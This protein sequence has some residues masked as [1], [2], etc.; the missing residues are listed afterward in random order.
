MGL[1]TTRNGLQIRQVLYGRSNA[2]LIGNGQDF[3]LVDT[4]RRNKLERLEQKFKDYGVTPANLSALILTHGHFDRAENAAVIQENYHT[5]VVI[6]RCEAGYL[7]HGDSP[8]PR[9][10]NKVTRRLSERFVPVLQS[11]FRY[12]P[13]KADIVIEDRYDLDIHG[14]RAYLIHTP[15]HSPGSVSVIVDD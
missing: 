11:H 15:G 12:Q 1:W 3:L 9:G 8:L 10:T 7:E 14:F 5:K 4:G 13:V 2:F 6:H